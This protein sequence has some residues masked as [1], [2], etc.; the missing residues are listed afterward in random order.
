MDESTLCETHHGECWVH[1]GQD[2]PDD[3]PA[4][5]PSMEAR[6]R[7]LDR[8]SAGPS[9]RLVLPSPFAL[10]SEQH[11]HS[12]E[13]HCSARSSENDSGGQLQH[14]DPMQA[15]SGLEAASSR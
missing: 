4:V 9:P 8:T 1:L 2:L 5:R 6:R 10:A 12:P 3:I 14:R 15:Y 11:T 7:Y 13:G